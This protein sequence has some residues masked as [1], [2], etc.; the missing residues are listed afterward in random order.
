M[1]TLSI[2][3]MGLTIM[4]ATGCNRAKS[5]DAV[6]KDVA[7]AEQKASTELADS[8]RDAS[9][10]MAKQAD[11]VGDRLAQLDDSAAKD[12]YR[13]ALARADGDRKVAL[14]K[15]DALSGDAHKNCRDQAD[16]DYDA[17]QA[18]A[19]AAEISQRQ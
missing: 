14:A 1:R 17:A 18:N 7:A 6:A 11:Q 9:K 10:D 2:I 12:G 8:R 13:I 16:A 4:V 19:K 5:P 15:C 3:A